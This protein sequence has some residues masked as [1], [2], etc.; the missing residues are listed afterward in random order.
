M[1]HIVY[2]VKQIMETYFGGDYVIPEKQEGDT[3]SRL[4]TPFEEYRHGVKVFLPITLFCDGEQIDLECATISVSGKKK[5][6]KVDMSERKGTVKEVFS[7]DD[8]Q[9]TI[10][11][12]LI[13]HDNCWPDDQMSLLQS[14][15]E[16][17]KVVELRCALS[18]YFLQESKKVCIETLQLYGNGE[19]KEKRHIPFSMTCIS[20]Y[21]DELELV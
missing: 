7:M 15:F 18:D 13:D 17:A 1:S 21:I 8:Y 11:G 14:M 4:G 3:L 5:I 16:T 2:D 20:D 19:S 12:V 9:F 10:N 6:N